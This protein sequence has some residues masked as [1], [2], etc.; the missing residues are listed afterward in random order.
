MGSLH[1]QSVVPAVS[2]ALRKEFDE[3]ARTYRKG[4]PVHKRTCYWTHNIVLLCYFHNKHCCRPRPQDGTP[5]NLQDKGNHLQP[6]CIPSNHSTHTHW[7]NCSTHPCTIQHSRSL[8]LQRTSLDLWGKGS[9]HWRQANTILPSY[10][11]RHN[12]FRFMVA[13]HK[14]LRVGVFLT[15]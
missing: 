2:G 9:L 10:M 5:S 6:L 11:F 13:A 7:S 4:L 3:C 12:M 1:W 14:C 15:L 8:G